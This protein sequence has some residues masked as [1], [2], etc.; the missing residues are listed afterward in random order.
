MLVPKAIVSYAKRHTAKEYH[1]HFVLNFL[2]HDHLR[3]NTALVRRRVRRDGTTYDYVTKKDLVASGTAPLDKDFLATFTKAYPEVF[4]TFRAATGDGGQ[5]LNFEPNEASSSEIAAK[6]AAHLATIPPGP[7]AATG[8]HRTVVGILEF[9]LYPWLINPVVEQKIH[10]GRKRIDITFDNAAMEG[11]FLHLHGVSQIPCRF[12]F[13]EC[14]NYTRDVANPEVDQIAGRF[15]PNRGKCGIIVCRDIQD[16]DRLISR[17]RD[18]F[19]DSRG[20]I[21]PLTDA[22]LEAALQ[23]KAAGV[24]EP[25]ADIL[26]DLYRSVAL[27]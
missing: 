13:V 7:D 25:L 26:G 3:L 23:L 17:C 24:R 1:Q 8:Y 4:R 22:D 10:D 2:Q 16:R 14:K 9:L 6:L 5:S 19:S 21:L 15:S 27:G 20:L 12:I 11:F 18:T